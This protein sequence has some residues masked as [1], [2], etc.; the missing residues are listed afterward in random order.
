LVDARNSLDAAAY[1]VERLL[2]DRGDAVPEHE[3]ARAEVL[4]GDAR[5]ALG[6]QE[7]PF[8]RIR[9][10]T[11][12]LQSLAQALTVAGQPAGAGGQSGGQSGRTGGSAGDGENDDD[13]IDA[14][15]STS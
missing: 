9:E 1:Q 14:E 4:V 8:E 13:V 2:A 10:L 6:D 11:G 15:F 5:Q 7:T 3:R 12:D